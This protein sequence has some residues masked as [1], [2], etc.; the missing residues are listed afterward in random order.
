MIGQKFD[1]IRSSIVQINYPPSPPRRKVQWIKQWLSQQFSFL[2]SSP[3]P[4]IEGV[5]FSSIEYESTPASFSLTSA[6]GRICS[7][8]PIAAGSILGKNYCLWIRR[9]ESVSIPSQQRLIRTNLKRFLT[10]VTSRKKA[11]EARRWFCFKHIYF[12]SIHDDGNR[13]HWHSHLE[14]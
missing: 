14:N 7:D 13:C 1:K 8:S 10:E 4:F 9:A 5:H 6:I 2:F 12:V 3:L 11:F